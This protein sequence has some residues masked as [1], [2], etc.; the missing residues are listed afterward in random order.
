M[1]RARN[2]LC[3]HALYFPDFFHQVQLRRQPAGRIRDQHVRAARARL[4][5]GPRRAV[6]AR[7]ARVRE[8]RDL[9]ARARER[10]A[11]TR[12]LAELRTLLGPSA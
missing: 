3:D 7:V 2:R 12:R 4:P 6:V 10:A 9:L 11:Q 8:G 5:L 1:R